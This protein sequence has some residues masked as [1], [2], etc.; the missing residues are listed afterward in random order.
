MESKSLKFQE[1][2]RQD[3]KIRILLLEDSP[4]DAELVQYELKQAGLHFTATVVETEEDY[5]DS[6][7]EFAPDL[8]LSDYDLPTYDG[9]Q[10]PE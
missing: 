5:K 9:A 7:S 6:L 10:N 4:D 3:R 2:P 8:I 1:K